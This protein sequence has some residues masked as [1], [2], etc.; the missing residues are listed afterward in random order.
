MS[1]S[2]LEEL[3]VDLDL[4]A[5]DKTTILSKV[6]CKYDDGWF[7]ITNDGICHL[8]DEDGNPDDIKKITRLK[9][10]YIRKDI[11]KIVIPDSTMSIGDYAFYDCYGLT[12]VIIPASVTSIG[13]QTFYNCR[14]LANMTIPDGVTSIEIYAFSWCIKLTSVTIPDSVTSIGRYAFEYCSNLINLTFKDKTLEQ[15]KKIRGYPWG[16][17]DESIIQV[18]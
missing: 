2:C 3:Q 6:G 12:N 18:G 16:I 13:Y 7:V 17:E 14:N 4:Y 5:L 9:E 11:T 8:F 15:V 1:Y 10:D